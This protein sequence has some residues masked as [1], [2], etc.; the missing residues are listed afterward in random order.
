VGP[1]AS[2]SAGAAH[3]ASFFPCFWSLRD[4]IPCLPPA[5]LAPSGPCPVSSVPA[6]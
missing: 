5:A 6:R 4:L 3:T 2:A 1:R